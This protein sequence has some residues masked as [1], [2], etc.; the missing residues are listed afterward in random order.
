LNNFT[1][2]SIPTDVV[3]T[4][5]SD[6]P[7]WLWAANSFFQ[8]TDSDDDLRLSGLLKCVSYGGLEKTYNGSFQWELARVRTQSSNTAGSI[9]AGARGKDLWPALAQDFEGWMA[10]R[11]DM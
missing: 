9:A 10:M 11:P 4:V 5:C 1:G 2:S 3:P 6:F 8:V 7:G